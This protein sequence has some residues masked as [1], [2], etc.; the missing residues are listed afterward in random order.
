MSF[1]WGLLTPWEP[2][3]VMW[4]NENPLLFKTRQDARAWAK[5]HYGYIKYR[6]DL[7]TEPHNWR[8][9]RPTLVKVHL[10]SYETLCNV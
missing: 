2:Y 5:E 7:R 1:R 4:Y 8:M 3:Q 9:P 10:E 6:K